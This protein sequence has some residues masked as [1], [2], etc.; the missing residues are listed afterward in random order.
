MFQ[1]FSCGKKARNLI[2][3]GSFQNNAKNDTSL[4]FFD[5]MFSRE[6]K[7]GDAIVRS[8]SLPSAHPLRDLIEATPLFSFAGSHTAIQNT[9]GASA[10]ALKVHT[11][12]CVP[13]PNSHL[14]TSPG[15][16]LLTDI[17]TQQ[18]K[19]HQSQQPCIRHTYIHTQDMLH[20]AFAYVDAINT[21]R[22]PPSFSYKPFYFYADTT[23]VINAFL[24]SHTKTTNF[25]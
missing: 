6:T 2:K 7:P 22:I 17:S 14:F 16:S 8:K 18:K 15:P 25:S 4:A 1:S 24:S 21:C 20:L 13:H 5:R 11:S 3:C 10:P 19:F 23:Q 12:I 9:F